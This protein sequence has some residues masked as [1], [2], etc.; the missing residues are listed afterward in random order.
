MIISQV[1]S[2]FCNN[3]EKTDRKG[4]VEWTDRQ[5]EATRGR[6]GRTQV[7]ATVAKVSSHFL[8]RKLYCVMRKFHCWTLIFLMGDNDMPG[9]H[10][11]PTGN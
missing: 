7:P 4:K 8:K 6:E 11:R 10:P 1:T 5:M 9:K 3:E 2:G